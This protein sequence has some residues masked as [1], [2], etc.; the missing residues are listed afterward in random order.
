MITLL[1]LEFAAG[2]RIDSALVKGMATRNPPDSEPG[3]P[4]DAVQF[5]RLDGVLGA[6]RIVAAVVTEERTDQQLI[7]LNQKYE[8]PSCHG[9]EDIH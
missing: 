1:L 2:Y 6:C 8:K 5:D 3:A 7:P 9:C 4:E